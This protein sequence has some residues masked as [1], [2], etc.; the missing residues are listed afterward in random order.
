MAAHT[1]N[2]KVLLTKSVLMQRCADRCRAG[3]YFHVAGVVPLERAPA[4]VRK[5]RDLYVVH[6]GKDARYR[7]KRAGLGN[8][9]LLLWQHD[10]GLR[11]LTFVLLVTGGDHPAHQLE[12]LADVR[13]PASRLVITGYELIRQTRP[14]SSAPAVTWRMTAQTYQEWRNRIIAAVR[15]RDAMGLRQAW[16]SLHRAPGFAP[17]RRQARAIAKLARAEYGRVRSGPFPHSPLRLRYVERLPDKALPLSA[18][19]ADDQRQNPRDED[20]GARCYTSGRP[21]STE[22]PEETR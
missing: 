11:E 20:S 8:A 19:L 12:R 7:R 5:F 4:L 2:P 18:V 10:R 16:W 15:G 21:T 13:E 3:Y 22:E 1:Y 14:D 6:L 17:I 9:H